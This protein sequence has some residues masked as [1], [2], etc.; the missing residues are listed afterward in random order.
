M[1][2]RD[3]VNRYS[4]SASEIVAGAI[5]DYKRGIVVGQ[6]TFG[7]GT[8]QTLEDLSEGQIKI[9]ESKYYRVSG[10]ST[11]NKGVIPDIELPVTWDINTVGE[12][13][14]P[15]AMPWDVIRPY[16]HKKYQMN[17]GLINDLES[18]YELRLMKEPNLDYLKKV[19]NRYDFNKNKKFLS[20]NLEERI[21]QKE[22]RKDWLFKIENDRR[23]KIGLPEFLSYQEMED[24]NDTENS[25]SNDI[26]LENDY[27]LIEST[28][29]INDYIEFEKKIILTTTK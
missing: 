9:T 19:R 27:H 6:K 15:T 28:N 11:Q 12:S 16:R 4:A 17:P 21:I 14:Y 7:K 1:C 22:S 26:N 25:Y 2:I 5:Q 3:R 23:I 10:M 29:I 20:L 13:S 8:V 24:F 18:K